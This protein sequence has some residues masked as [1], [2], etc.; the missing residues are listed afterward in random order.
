M[1]RNVVEKKFKWI[2]IN[3]RLKAL[4]NQLV[5]EMGIIILN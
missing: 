5:T 4:K 3:W 2:Q 1:N